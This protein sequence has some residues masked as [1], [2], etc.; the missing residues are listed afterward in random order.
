[1]SIGYLYLPQ[2]FPQEL[3]FYKTKI[4]NPI[5]SMLTR[6]LTF[7]L[8]LACQNKTIKIGNT[9]LASPKLKLC[10]FQD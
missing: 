1:M 2:L 10:I 6:D 7:F 8:A 3:A 5:P 9:F 4:G